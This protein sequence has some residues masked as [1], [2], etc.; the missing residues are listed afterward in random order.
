ISEIRIEGHTSSEWNEHVSEEEAYL[1]NME[2]SQGRTRAVLTYFLRHEAIN[3]HSLREHI[4]SRLT[5]N[6][7]SSSHP[8]LDSLGKED[9]VRS[10]RVEIRFQQ[11]RDR[12]A[13]ELIR[14]RHADQRMQRGFG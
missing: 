6:G 11:K 2:L 14:R 12:E 7:L 8:I 5:A 4:R 1:L 9:T 3:R 10:R 13:I